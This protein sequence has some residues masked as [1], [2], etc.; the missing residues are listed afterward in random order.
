MS[1][2]SINGVPAQFETAVLDQR[3]ESYRNAYRQT[4]QC[5]EIVRATIPNQFLQTVADKLAEGYLLSKYPITLEPIN[6]SAHLIKPPAMQEIDIAR[7]DAEIKE[8]Y[9]QELENGLSKYKAKLTQ[10]IIEA[11]VVKEAKKVELAKAKR[12]LEIKKEVDNCYGVLL[13]PEQK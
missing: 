3:Q 1:K 9:I 8:K 5:C 7:I 13:I 6:Y 10:Q 2:I 4:S 12:L 11:D